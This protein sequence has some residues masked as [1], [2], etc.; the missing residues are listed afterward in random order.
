M[1]VFSSPAA[2]NRSGRPG[3]VSSFAA[4]FSQTP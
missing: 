1:R 3:D 4:T 2:K